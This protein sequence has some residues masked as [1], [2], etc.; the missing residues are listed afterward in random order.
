[1]PPGKLVIPAFVEETPVVFVH[2][3]LGLHNIIVSSSNPSEIVGI[4]DW[5]FCGSLPYPCLDY[6]IERLF[7]KSPL[8]GYRPEYDHAD[9]LRDAFWGAIPSWTEWNKSEAVKV[10]REWHQFGKFMK[11]EPLGTGAQESERERVWG[12]HEKVVREFL[13]KWAPNKRSV[14]EYIY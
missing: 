13:L 1:M 10:F 7:R 3:D 14:A 6:M 5:E 12:H 2:S 9:Q 11:P 4:I 8:N